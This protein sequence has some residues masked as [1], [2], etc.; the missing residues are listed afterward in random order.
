MREEPPAG[1]DARAAQPGDPE[2]QVGSVDVSSSA[3]S[4]PSAAS[5]SSEPS[6]GTPKQETSPKPGPRLRHRI[7]RRIRRN[8]TLDTTWRVGV[9]VVG[10]LFVVAG[11]IMFIAPG[12]GW[13]TIIL[14]LAILAT[15]FAWAHRI[16]HWTKLKAQEASAKAFDPRVRKRNLLI[17][18]GAAIVVVAGATLWVTSFGWPPPLLSTVEWVRSWR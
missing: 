11:L 6:R 8:R 10:A 3:G 18:A 16:L 7:R 17:T 2:Q 13:L 14:G 4:D 12:P 15:E 9:F 5:D 1:F